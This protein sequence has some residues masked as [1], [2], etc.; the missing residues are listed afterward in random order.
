MLDDIKAQQAAR[1]STQ[2]VHPLVGDLAVAQQL[3]AKAQETDD[4]KQLVGILH[5]LQFVLMAMQTES[6]A[7]LITTHIER[8]RLELLREQPS[9]NDIAAASKQLMAALQASLHV[10]PAELV[11]PVLTK[12]EAAK[13]TLDEG[14]ASAARRL[15]EDAQS[16]ASGHK[17]N[18]VLRSALAACKGAEEALNRSAR[19]VVNAELAELAAMLDKVEAIAVV[20]KVTE[21]DADNASGTN[22]A[23]QEVPVPAATDAPSD[24]PASAGAGTQ[25]PTGAPATTGAT[26]SG[27]RPA[28][29]AIPAAKQ[30]AL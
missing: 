12:L 19:P 8:A 30:P 10:E 2:G 5:R 25:P 6:P 28:T 20:Q 7:G 22:E 18:A 14:D 1:E 3:A 23:A 13:K 24:A 9:E 21:G 11:P 26:A 16:V 27:P 17:I 29:P 15:L 4:A